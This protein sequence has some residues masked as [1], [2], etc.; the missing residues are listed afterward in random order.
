M[1]SGSLLSRALGN[2]RS[3]VLDGRVVDLGPFRVVRLNRRG[4]LSLAANERLRC[5]RRLVL[6]LV[7]DHV[8]VVVLRERRRVKV[9]VVWLLLR[10]F[11]C[12]IRPELLLGGHARR[13]SAS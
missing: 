11:L 4:R 1:L 10:E 12:T 9:A 13:T 3:V 5:Q 7:V 6:A 2:D 8:V